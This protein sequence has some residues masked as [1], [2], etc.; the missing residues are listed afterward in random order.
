MST[1][2]INKHI[3]DIINIFEERNCR[4][5]SE[6]V[7][8]Q[9]PITYICVCGEQKTKKYKD[10]KD[11]VG[12]RTCIS[13]KAN[14]EDYESEAGR[15]E[16]DPVSGEIWKRIKGGWISSIG[17][18][19]NMFDC[20]LDPDEK[21]RYNVNKKHQYASRLV[22]VAFEIEGYE[23]LNTQC[24]VVHHIDNNKSNN[25][26][27]NL[28]IISKSEVNSE[29]GKKSHKSEKFKKTRK[30]KFGDFGSIERT[31]IDILPEHI[32]F[33][34]GMIWNGKNF[35]TGSENPDGYI[36]CCFKKKQYYLNRIVCFAFN[37]LDGKNKYEDYEDL[38]ANHKDGEKTNNNSENLEWVDHSG[39]MSHAYDTKLNKSGREVLQYEK[40]TNRF[41]MEYPSISNA[42]SKTG[43]T[44]WQIGKSAKGNETPNSIYRWE[45]KH[46][47][48]TAEFSKKYSKRS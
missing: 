21:C 1:N 22:A 3:Q 23:K 24:H 41:M 14:D 11:T 25:N 15:T 2:T 34:N 18:C 38:E 43:E 6:L 46:P 4:I 47:E 36:M 48:Q 35:L 33:K 26:V 29:N 45:Y 20:I 10:F 40:D 9:T 37:K 32:I 31:V 27:E 17:R 5:I 39:N 19:R 42:S 44:Q 30:I 28:T 16:I 12:C 7:N 8:K 13:K